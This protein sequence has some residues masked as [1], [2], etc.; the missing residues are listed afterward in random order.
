[1]EVRTVRAASAEKCTALTS[2]NIFDVPAGL[3]LWKPS[4]GSIVTIMA[5]KTA[6]T[7]N[8]TAI[9]NEDTDNVDWEKIPKLT[10][11]ATIKN[12][13]VKYNLTTA[14]EVKFRL[15]NLRLGEVGSKVF[16]TQT[17]GAHDE[18]LSVEKVPAG[19]YFLIIKAG[20]KVA[21][22]YVVIKK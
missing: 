14:S 22:R 16:A 3:E 13:R 8:N 18:L 5:P 9:G 7:D 17:V 6:T 12:I 10:C 1:M 21:A 15:L 2:K 11:D 4:N 19:R 20:K